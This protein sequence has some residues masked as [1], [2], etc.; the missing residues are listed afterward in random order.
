VWVSSAGT[1][2]PTRVQIFDHATAVRAG[3]DGLLLRLTTTQPAAAAPIRVK[4]G[5]GSFRYAYGGDWGARLRLVELSD[6]A[7]VSPVP[8][9]CRAVPL[10]TVNDPSTA[11]L[12]ATVPVPAGATGALVAAAASS[13]S[14]AGSF[15]A[16]SLGLPG[17]WSV[18]GSSGG[19]EWSY[20]LRTPPGVGGPVPSLGLSYS[21][22]AV[23]GE[24]ATT[25]NQP[26][27]IGEGF[28]LSTGYI[29]R[30]YRTCSDDMGNGA[31]NTAPT[32]DQCWATNNAALSM[33]GH[34]G[35]LIQDGSDP[36]R[37][38]LRNDD[39]TYIRH[40]TGASNG[41]NGGEYWVVTTP[42]G[43]QYWFGDQAASNS[44]WTEPVYGNNPGEP[45]YTTTFA[46]SWCTQ[47]WRWN[48]DHVVDPSG[49]TMDYFYATETNAYARALNTSDL[50]TYVRG[51]YL[52]R[53]TYG[54]RTGSTAPAPVQVVF[55]TANRCLS[56]CTTQDATH[57][58]DTPWDQ[59]CT[60]APCFHGSPT[61][62]ITQRLAQITTELYSG[63]GST[64]TPVTQW[65]LTHTFPDP[66]DGTRAGLWLSAISQT[67]LVGMTTTAPDVTFNPVQ[68]QN[69]VDPIDLGLP[70][71]N[72]MR[73]AQINTGTGGQIQVSYSAPDCVAG[74]RVPNANDLQDNTYRCYPV[75][76][77]PSG[78]SSPITDFFQKYVVTSVNEVDLT[79]SGNPTSVTSYEYV[80]TPAWHYTDDD[81]IIDSKAKTWSVW[82]GYGTI[83][84]HVGVGG[85]ETVTETQYYRGMD[86]D[87]LSSGTRSVTLPAVDLNLDGNTTD[88]ADVPAA[89]DSDAFNGMTR[90]TITDNGPSG[91]VV[92][93][94]VDEAWQSPPT[95]T[96]T[97]NG[98]TVYARFTGVATTH[99][100]TI[101]DGGRAP[102]TTSKHTTFD[103]FGM[104]ILEQ[105]NGDDAVTG[106]ERCAM[107]D[108]ARNA[109]TNGSVWLISFPY[110]QRTFA[111]DCTTAQQSGLPAADVVTD[112]LT[113]YDGTTTAST[114]PTRGLPTRV[115]TLKDWVSGA[116]VYQTR[117]Q[118]G[119]DANG[120]TVSATDVRGNTTTTAFAANAG[121]QVSSTTV[122]NALGWTTTTTVE[123][124]FGT[125]VHTVDPNGRIS[126]TTLDGLG[127]VTAVWQPG[128]D[129]ATQTA[130]ASYSYLVQSTAPTVVTSNTL[131]PSGGYVTS[132]QL[133][134]GLLRPRQTQAP[135]ADGAAGTLIT[136]TFYDTAGRAWKTYAPYL[137]AVT[138]GSGLF[139]ANEQ[140]DVPARTE[141]RFDGA[142]RQTASILFV[143]N[144]SGVPVEFSRTTTA[145]G[146]DRVDVTPPA[147]GT[148]SSTVTNGI[149]EKIQTLVYHGATPTPTVVGSYDATT[150]AYDHK[151]ELAT[152]TD[153]SGN[154]WTKTYDVRGRLVG[155]S[156]PDTGSSSVT[157]NDAGDILTTTDARG[158]T[159]AYTY[160]TLGRKTG[161]YLGSVAPAN[162]RAEWD[163]DTLSNSRGQL[164]RS[165]RYDSGN[166]YVMAVGG[167]NATY[168]PTAVTYTIPTAE[169]G[170]AGTYTYVYTYAVN[171]AQ[172]TTRMPHLD[173]TGGLATETLTQNYT[174]LGQPA[175][176]STSLPTATT[177]VPSL[178]YT[179]YGE[180]GVLTMQ[181]NGGLTAYLAMTYADGTRRLAEAQA[182]TQN[183]PSALSDVHYTYD[184]AGNLLSADDTATSDNQCYSYDYLDRLTSAW[185]PANG[186]CTAAKST[187]ALGGPAPYWTDWTFDVTGNRTSQV[188]HATVAGVRTTTYTVPTP[189]AAQP[190]ALTGTT[191]VDGS[192]TRTA[193]YG[194]DAAGNT[195]ARPS[196]SGSGSQSLTWDAEGHLATLTDNGST[197]SYLYDVGGTRLISRDSTGKT[198]YLPGQELRYTSATGTKA[199]TRYYG[200]AGLTVAMRTTAGLTWL[201]G[202]RQGTTNL[203][204]DAAS[205]TYSSRL[206]DPYGNPRGSTTGTW[207]TAM[208]KGYV[209]GTKDATGL[210]HLGAREYD[211]TTGR[212]VSVDPV[213]NYDNPQRLDPYAY[214]TDNPVGL[215]DPAGAD[216]P[217][218]PPGDCASG[219]THED[220]HF[221]SFYE[222]IGGYR[223]TFYVDAYFL[224]RDGGSQCWGFGASCTATT[225][226]LGYDWFPGPGWLFYWKVRFYD[227]LVDVEQLGPPPPP[228][229]ADTPQYNE[230]R[231]QLSQ[232]MAAA[233]E[234]KHRQDC[235]LLN[236]GCLFGDPGTWLGENYGNLL[237]I[238]AAALCD[239]ATAGLCSL[240]LLPMTIGGAI[241]DTYNFLS[242]QQNQ[243]WTN[244][245]G[246]GL[247]FAAALFPLMKINPLQK[248]R[249]AQAARDAEALRLGASR[250]SVSAG[251]NPF[252][253]EI[254]VGDS[255]FLCCAERRVAARLGIP[256][257]DVVFVESV[258]PRNLAPMAVCITC[259]DMFDMTQFPSGTLADPDG[260]WG[261]SV[262]P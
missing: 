23:D 144:S 182:V 2:T 216:A 168:Q 40:L 108:Y 228:P 208:T 65:T 64:Y 4:V 58:P 189:G 224:C 237:G 166:Q 133:Y 79:T 59:Q 215:A 116:P 160:D 124:S 47:A 143:R 175:S 111:T 36:N 177:L 169:T 13:S 118:T 233:A 170:L 37:W 206:Q 45:C 97:I 71:M 211:P 261:V 84:T 107:T 248:F 258:R 106:D 184:A 32:G 19:F 193:S 61:F 60:A 147:G 260:R 145:Y 223:Y 218:P 105:D 157:Y 234:E 171:G 164:T 125:T 140:S 213:A 176:L 31:N 34:A 6:C 83:R 192:G 250:A 256:L 18:G 230:Y 197:T 190:H 203:T 201:V 44:T 12:A 191:V 247:D 167:L 242:S 173:A 226:T 112:T 29:Q 259:Q 49:N 74:T 219:C 119:Y 134:D 244:A 56:N 194:Y 227:V 187:A 183:A 200:E 101:R 95:A 178:Q 186:D 243:T 155:E 252:T 129:K 253:G 98:V 257:R 75:I 113:Y 54:T 195:T 222:D 221:Y 229:C 11:A 231:Q 35:D 225:C 94:T 151:Q 255:N 153:A 161:L 123:P 126:D 238:G 205:Q 73:I 21:S 249:V 156:D 15:G 254:A 85:D 53:I 8:T 117:S 77:T 88:P 76:W 204:V 25:N 92:S 162:Q 122:T 180:L 198:L 136:D 82:R 63:T 48:L 17:T 181:T 27:W 110:R 38:H 158:T 132:Y 142:S 135:R 127:R 69:R 89:T 114:P 30:M 137:A 42:D 55:T 217:G 81:G 3:V 28:D 90:A 39:G 66:G 103:A 100:Q 1:A 235:T 146:G 220:E 20:P 148:A 22:Q 99:T 262:V 72:W 138:P 87:H 150:Y 179:G 240:A 43:V 130:N 199:T 209:G 188:E 120:R 159:L 149:G 185:T 52:T 91:P 16:T 102:I 78:D 109:A 152:I 174:A 239:A 5:Y 57:W 33:E 212:L 62:W 46:T 154:Q 70:P 115:D 163:Y 121:G 245:A 24:M 246:L 41:A 128:R 251:Y 93:Q 104:P 10:A 196:Q 86:G 96:R 26:S 172:L 67:G 202:D 51:G 236:L 131:T 210:T 50:A 9:G 214:C 165:V 207:P 80:G 14:G 241:E 141:L 232:A 7:T 68:L 139:V